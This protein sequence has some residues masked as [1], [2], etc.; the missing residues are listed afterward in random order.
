[1]IMTADAKDVAGSAEAA[2]ERPEAFTRAAGVGPV[3]LIA[4]APARPGPGSPAAR[5]EL[6]R[7]MDGDRESDEL[8][9]ARRVRPPSLFMPDATALACVLLHVVTGGSWQLVVVLGFL[10]TIVCAPLA[11]LGFVADA[12][13]ALA[14]RPTRVAF[15]GTFAL[16]AAVGLLLVFLFHV[17]LVTPVMLDLNHDGRIGTTGASTARVPAAYGPSR[18][19]AFD[20]AGTGRPQQVAWSDGG[21]DAF[22]V[23]DRDGGATRA[24]RGDGVIDGKRLF[25]DEG[26]RY[27]SGYDK[28]AL[29]DA[30]RDGALTGAEL[31]GL[32]AWIDD[33]DARLSAAELKPLQALGV[34]RLDVRHGEVR[35]ARGEDLDQAGFTING[36]RGLTEDVWF[37][38]VR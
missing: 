22:V 11:A 29:L 30:D 3:L 36:R 23:D 12:C 13:R 26:G 16:R 10:V 28:L 15:G 2:A 37:G 17:N 24:A 35:N 27:A 25:G 31:A 33:G 19:V 1:M 38:I 18:T 7:L 21:G 32:A 34:T 4:M 9:R 5:A 20:L 8:R 14:N 6:A